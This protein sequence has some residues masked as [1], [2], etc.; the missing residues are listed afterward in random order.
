MVSTLTTRCQFFCL[1]Q[2]VSIQVNKVCQWVDSVQPDLAK[3]RHFGTIL[4]ALGKFLMVY[5][6]FGKILII[7]WQKCFNIGQVFIV[8][9]GQILKNNF[10]ISS[11]WV[12]LNHRSQVLA[13]ATLPTE[14]QPLP[15]IVSFRAAMQ[16]WAR[17][18]ITRGDFNGQLRFL[19]CHQRA[20]H[21]RK[22]S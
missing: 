8:V 12:D 16:I 1:F 20:V 22:I 14:P 9:D 17:S 2:K 10:G 7:L 13:A 15:W 3:F 11:H 18:I 4:K 19:I 21:K 6:V 5:L